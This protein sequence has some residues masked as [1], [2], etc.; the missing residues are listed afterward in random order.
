MISDPIYSNG[1]MITASRLNPLLQ[2]FYL[3]DMQSSAQIR[4]S[5]VEISQND[6]SV[7]ILTFPPSFTS[8]HSY[9]LAINDGIITN[10][11]GDSLEL[12]SMNIYFMIDT[13]CSGHGDLNNGRCFCCNGYAGSSCQYCDVSYI[14]VDTTGTNM[15]CKLSLGQNCLIDTC[16]CDP[17][18][19]NHGCYGQCIPIGICSIGD[20]TCRCPTN[21]AGDH[22]ESCASG[23]TNW[24]GGCTKSAVCGTCVHGVCSGNL[25]MCICDDHYAGSTCEECAV[26]WS[27]DNC[28]VATEQKI[29]SNYG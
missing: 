21:Y 3:Q 7:Y 16:G 25:A 22:C 27:G 14:N 1:V 17:Q 15:T 20:G 8:L 23:Y 6:A 4:P 12:L 18:V 13:T 11:A 19:N 29:K 2:T 5:A 9:K 24:E 28:D 26:G 10:I